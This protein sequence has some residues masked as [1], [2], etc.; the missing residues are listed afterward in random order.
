MI[1]EPQNLPEYLVPKTNSSNPSD[2]RVFHLKRIEG[3]SE[4]E[5]ERLK[6]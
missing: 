2:A 4:E 3:L 6:K 1:F 5:I